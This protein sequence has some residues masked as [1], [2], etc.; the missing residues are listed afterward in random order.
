MFIFF[1]YH[2]IKPY[3]AHVILIS[4][5]LF[6]IDINKKCLSQDLKLVIP[7]GHTNLVTKIALSENKKFIA[8][9]DGSN[10]LTLWDNINA[11]E[12]TSFSLES[13]ISSMLFDSSWLYVGMNNGDLK[14]ISLET[15]SINSYLLSL[16]DRAVAILK[17]DSFKSIFSRSGNILDVNNN[18][19]IISSSNIPYELNSVFLGSKYIYLGSSDGRLI[20]LEKESKEVEKIL[21]LGSSQINDLEV[22]PLGKILLCSDNRGIIYQI[23]IEEHSLTNTYQMFSLRARSFIFLSDTKILAV[24]RDDISNIK[25][26]DLTTG[27]ISSYKIWE[28]ETIYESFPIG[29]YVLEKP[30][31]ENIYLSGYNQNILRL[32]TLGN[33]VSYKGEASSINDIELDKTGTHLAIASQNKQLSFID[34]TGKTNPKYVVTPSNPTSIKWIDQFV[35]AGLADG[36][37]LIINQD[38]S[39]LLSFGQKN[40]YPYSKLDVNMAQGIAIR[41]IGPKGLPIINLRE[42]VIIRN[43]KK[44]G[45]YY[46]FHP[47]Q[48]DLL[49]LNSKK[50]LEVWSASSFKKERTFSNTD[51]TVNFQLSENGEILVLQNSNGFEIINYK[52]EKSIS[53]IEMPGFGTGKVY[54]NPNADRLYLS[55]STMIKGSYMAK[56]YISVVDVF[57]GNEIHQLQGHT[58]QVTDMLFVNDGK[59]ILSSG[60]DGTIKIWDS[61][62]KFKADIIPLMNNEHVVVAANGLF[63]ATQLSMEKISFLQ[64]T[65][66]IELNQVK[67]KY[68]EPGLLSKI[69]EFNSETIRHVDPLTHIKLYPEFELLHPAF[70]N[71]KLGINPIIREGGMGRIVILINGK[72]ISTVPETTPNIG[73]EYDISSHPYL[74]RGS[75]NEISVKIYN[76][77]G[78]AASRLR[79]IFYLDKRSPDKTNPKLYGL[80]IGISDYRGDDLDLEFASND[81]HAMANAISMAAND[82]LGNENVQVTYL[83]T[84]QDSSGSHWPSKKNI[85]KALDE[86][87]DKAK[88]RDILFLYISGHGQVDKDNT[89]EFYYLT[90]D[91]GERNFEDLE[92]RSQSLISNNEL[93]IKIQ[94]IA[95]IKQVLVIDACHSGS[96]LASLSEIPSSNVSSVQSRSFEQLKDKSGMYIIAGSADNAV[97]YESSMFGHG[98]LTYSLLMGMKGPG[99]KENRYVDIFQLFNYASNQVPGLASEIGGI[100]KPEI[101]IPSSGSF[102]IGRMNEEDKKSIEIATPKSIFISSVFQHESKF[103]DIEM[104]GNKID[105]VLRKFNSVRHSNITFISTSSYPDAYVLR[106]RYKTSDNRITADIKLFKGDVLIYEHSLS[107]ENVISLADQVVNTTINKLG[108][109][110]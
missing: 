7:K 34:L 64:G 10:G 85:F 16:N 23:D 81:A 31:S 29:L 6:F 45:Y 96:L 32:D 51:E 22:S 108:K 73:A 91:A 37:I 62:G 98:L 30:N 58:A 65:E 93:R 59:F 103:F 13:S 74:L 35:F 82:L 69:L 67:G 27:V 8:S 75:L 104:L 41:K 53:K 84:D 97:S 61:N 26:L 54:I 70:N 94:N 43:L 4:S 1:K 49:I 109:D 77:E 68:Y 21:E 76:K 99:L 79:N 2:N 50:Q 92:Y 89:Q 60:A 52:S 106:G 78:D 48:T 55:R 3:L 18:D 101:K 39:A 25:Q 56:H 86:I 40:E 14:K 11:K 5:L 88:A 57:K 102:D 36:R 28:D 46:K 110:K 38:S 87:A 63:D 20:I 72:E 12:I 24:G 9:S 33:K 95:A 107:H 19:S 100:Q 17:N 42:E 83:T 15:F 90:A 71:G 44:A 80:V 66:V 47:N 105:D